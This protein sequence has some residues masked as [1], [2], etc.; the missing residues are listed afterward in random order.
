MGFGAPP[1]GLGGLACDLSHP[2]SIG[3][4][5]TPR[6]LL[7]Q[8]RG[9]ILKTFVAVNRVTTYEVETFTA[10][11]AFCSLFIRAAGSTSSGAAISINSS[12]FSSC[13]SPASNFQTDESERISF[14]ADDL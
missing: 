5:R 8:I 10:T 2:G 1:C 13:R 14:G 6:P 3:L 9:L 11:S 7:T 12:T 4:A